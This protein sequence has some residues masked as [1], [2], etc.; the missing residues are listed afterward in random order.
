M[1][2]QDTEY[3]SQ[4]LTGI[5][6]DTI[7]D[8]GLTPAAFEQ[9]ST[10][11]WKALETL[12]REHADGGPLMRHAL[13]PDHV[14]S[15]QSAVE[16]L[17]VQ[18]SQIFLV[19]TGGSS[20]GAKTLCAANVSEDLRRSSGAAGALLMDVFEN[21]DPQTVWLSEAD[22]AADQAFIVISK[23]GTTSE[24]LAIFDRCWRL[25]FAALGEAAAARFLIVTGP[26]ESP[27]RRMA[28]QIGAEII[29]HEPDV[30]G[31]MSILSAV[32]LVPALVEGVDPNEVLAGAR[33]VAEQAV[34]A[35][36]I[37]ACAPALGAAMQVGLMRECGATVSV[38]MP[39]SEQLAEFSRWFC[40]LWAESL[41]KDGQGTMPY[42]A[43]GM[44]DQHSQL[45]FWLNGP[46]IGIYTLIDL[47]PASEELIQVEDP[48]LS[49]MA[50]RSFSQMMHAASR[51][52]ADTLAANGRPVRRLHLRGSS[53]DARTMGA[54]AMHFMI[55][56]VL[57]GYMLG[58]DPYTQPAVDT[59]KA[60]M[61]EY[62]SSS[63][64]I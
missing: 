30:C 23:S 6:A 43:R 20:L 54:L 3:Y 35:T 29:E 49:W 47:E 14:Q 42:P 25:S 52:T 12:R 45:Q 48:E 56:T 2:S 53:V 27:L 16:R 51:A 4:N 61:R 46:P 15:V 59:G 32:G 34:T 50:G 7:G 62:L 37:S 38:L 39:Y 31:R 1:A 9:S 13:R 28:E 21:A 26:Q 57:S 58:V 40:Q 5:F 10:D 64:S 33:T 17:T 24:T 55:E 22:D 18:A 36:D 63:P 41:G 19:G 60:L 11:A 8:A 44:V